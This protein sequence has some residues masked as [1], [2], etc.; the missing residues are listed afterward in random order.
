ML[1]QQNDW[2]RFN[3]V[4]LE[5]LHRVWINEYNKM[6]IANNKGISAE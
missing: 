4:Q 2:K 6:A 5:K 3:E 1:L